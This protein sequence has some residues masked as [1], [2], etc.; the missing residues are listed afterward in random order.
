ME[1]QHKSQKFLRIMVSLPVVLLLYNILL[2]FSSCLSTNPDRESEQY[3][4]NGTGDTL[5]MGV[6]TSFPDDYPR[7][8]RKV[9]ELYPYEKRRITEGLG[10]LSVADMIRGVWS[11][12]EKRD[13]IEVYKT[14]CDTCGGTPISDNHYGG[15][16]ILFMGNICYAKWGG[17]IVALPDSIHSFY[18]VNSWEV[19]EKGSGKHR[20][21]IA[22]FT[23]RPE[24]LK[25]IE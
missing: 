1:C 20:C 14:V 5:I 18:N 25:E 19:T 6:S 8:F 24:D 17:P 10:D 4:I 23:V 12:D 2:F 15:G 9:T 16:Q 21:I 11:Y 3:L 7:Y 13:T 22:T